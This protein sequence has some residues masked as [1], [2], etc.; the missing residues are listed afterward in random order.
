VEELLRAHNRGSVWLRGRQGIFFVSE[1]LMPLWF[2]I[3]QT[4]IIAFRVSASSATIIVTRLYI[5]VV[6]ATNTS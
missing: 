2:S 3:G 5:P 4:S 6:V 1:H